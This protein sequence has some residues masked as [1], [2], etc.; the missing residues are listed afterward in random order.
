MFA[1]VAWAARKGLREEASANKTNQLEIKRQAR[2]RGICGETYAYWYLRR[3]GY[4]FI[5]RNYTVP[6]IKGE[7]DL[8]GYDGATLAFVEVKTRTGGKAEY[9]LPEDSVRRDK[10]RHLARM[11]QQFLSERH[12]NEAPC[13]FDV[14]AI[15]SCPGKRPVTR[16]HKDAFAEPR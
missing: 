8:V 14:M 10:R 2:A 1:A 4:V 9:G 3:Y 12:I 16:L 6:G 15:E 5:A 7:I 11:A 13:R